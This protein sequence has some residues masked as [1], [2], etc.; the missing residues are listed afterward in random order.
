MTA[1][2]E[3]QLKHISVSS[4][5]NNCYLLHDEHE[6]LLIDAADNPDDLLALAEQAGVTITAVLTTHRHNDHVRA[7]PEVL[8]RTGATHYASFLDAPA[9]PAPVD[10]ELDQGD[11]IDFAGHELPVFI[12]RG[13]TPGGVGVAARI[14]GVPNLFVG[15]SIF[16]GGLGKTHSEGDFV[17]LFKDAKERVFDVYRDESIIYPG[18]G[19]ST[20]IGQER[21]HLDEWWE[22]RW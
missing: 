10:V 4:M 9:L 16:P 8:K 2:E 5:D 1:Q 6:G 12:L 11:H 17:R 14:D 3:L 22:R 7:L 20:T 18:H 13:H 21:P 19:D 15:D